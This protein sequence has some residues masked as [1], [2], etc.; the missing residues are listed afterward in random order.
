M[1]IKIASVLVD[2]QEKALA[3]YTKILGFT[4]KW[5]LPI[6]GDARFLTVVSPEDPDGTELLLEPNDNPALNGSAQAYQRSLFGAGI[7]ATA[8]VARD[9]AREYERMKG[10]G[11]VFTTPPTKLGMV[12]LAV[13]DDTCG[14]LIQ[15]FQPMQPGSV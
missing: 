7:P 13:F 10:L 6:G 14:N 11:V 3:F 5:D 2:N 9:I 12:T 8:F 4:K 15:I 1:Q